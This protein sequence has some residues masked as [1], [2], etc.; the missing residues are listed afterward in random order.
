MNDE[1]QIKKKKKILVKK[2]V[3]KEKSSNQESKEGKEISENES[4]IS[5][6]K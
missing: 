1:S 5:K 4:S 6:S 3:K 2:I